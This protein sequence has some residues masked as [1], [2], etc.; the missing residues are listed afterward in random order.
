MLLLMTLLTKRHLP[1][2]TQSHP[3]YYDILGLLKITSPFLNLLR[4]RYIVIPTKKKIY[5][6]NGS[7]NYISALW[8]RTHK[9]PKGLRES[10][11]TAFWITFS[12]EN[13]TCIRVDDEV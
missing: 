9:L 2:S 12:M 11:V 10:L 4:H 7:F 13:E 5:V 6:F 3:S 8:Y 1:T